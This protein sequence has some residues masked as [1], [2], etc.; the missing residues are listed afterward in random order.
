LHIDSIKIDKSFIDGI[1]ANFRDEELIKGILLLTKSLNITSI[2]EGVESEM[3][4]DFLK[5]NGC[6]KI[7]GYYYSKPLHIQMIIK[8]AV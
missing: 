3:Q 7:Q 5:K 2:A 8:K 6:N 1:G 4:V